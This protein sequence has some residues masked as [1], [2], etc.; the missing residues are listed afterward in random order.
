MCEDTS[1]ADGLFIEAESNRSS[2]TTV[3]EQ[4]QVF[5]KQFKTSRS[6]SGSRRR[7]TY[8]ETIWTKVNYLD[9]TIT[10]DGHIKLLLKD[11]LLNARRTKPSLGHTNWGGCPGIFNRF[12]QLVTSI[13][14]T[15]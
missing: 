4:S 3:T 6:K 9:D 10:P 8:H 1:E 2:P 15:Q 14:Y 12:S 13:Q 5:N 11:S 7:F